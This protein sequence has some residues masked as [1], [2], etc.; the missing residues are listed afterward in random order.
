MKTKQPTIEQMF[1]AGLH[2]GHQTRRWHPAME[3][4][5][6]SKKSDTHIIDLQ[7]TSDALKKACEVVYEVGKKGDSIILVATKDQHKK[8][9]IETAK[10]HGVYYV[11]ERW[12]GGIL[13]NFTEMLKNRGKLVT[14]KEGLETGAFVNYTKKERLMMQREVTK[15]ELLNGGLVG[16]QKLP[17]AV[18]VVDCKKEQTT[19]QE[20]NKTKVPVISLVDTNSNPKGVTHIIPGNDDAISSVD[21]IVKT[22]AQSFEEGKNEYEKNAKKAEAKAPEATIKKAK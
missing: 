21:L 20:C 12:L 17:G 15:L 5:I 2:Y 6:H 19:I 7:K 13:T 9:T 8:L 1:K 16:L 4:F 11:C 14:L 18:F 22:I 3:N 10:E